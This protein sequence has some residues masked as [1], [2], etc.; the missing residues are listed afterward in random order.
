MKYLTDKA[1]AERY[2]IARSTV[3]HWESNGMMPKPVKLNG[4]TRWRLSDLEEWEKVCV[5]DA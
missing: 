1:V 5:K 4:S 2:S 3:W